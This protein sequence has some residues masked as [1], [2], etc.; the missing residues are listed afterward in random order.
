MAL[1]ALKH[2]NITEI[3]RVREPF[4]GLVT[5]IAL[6]LVAL[7]AEIDRMDERASLHILFRRRG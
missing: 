1:D 2:R 6:V 3:D 5:E 4:V 7:R